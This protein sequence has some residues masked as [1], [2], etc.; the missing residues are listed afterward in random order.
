M[1]GTIYLRGRQPEEGIY[2]YST[3]GPSAI[4]FFDL[5][6][7]VDMVYGLYSL[8]SASRLHGPACTKSAHYRAVILNWRFLRLNSRPD[9][10]AI[11]NDLA[12]HGCK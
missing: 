12:R 2:S 7:G 11:S 1:G 8:A 6:N 5:Q 4:R 9:R 3:E 10:V